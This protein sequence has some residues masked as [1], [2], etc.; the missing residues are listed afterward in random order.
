[1]QCRLLGAGEQDKCVIGASIGARCPVGRSCLQEVLMV[2]FCFG[3]RVSGPG[4]LDT[5]WRL[6]VSVKTYA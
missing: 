5:G 6:T 1:M 3:W 2:I 4:V